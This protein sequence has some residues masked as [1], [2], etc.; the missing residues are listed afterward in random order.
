MQIS[1]KQQT[2][3]AQNSSFVAFIQSGSHELQVFNASN[4]P[5]PEGSGGA[6]DAQKIQ[7][8]ARLK[9]H[10]SETKKNKNQI[11]YTCVAFCSEGANESQLLV[12]TSDGQLVIVSCTEGKQ[13]DSFRKYDTS[14][15]LLI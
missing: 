6:T 1:G 10:Q 13:V 9:P 12:G 3:L 8:I 15:L 14:L 7:N 4:I 11:K 5:T 2:H